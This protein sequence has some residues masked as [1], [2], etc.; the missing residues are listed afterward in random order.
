MISLYGVITGMPFEEQS[1][2][3]IER[4]DYLL[5]KSRLIQQK[6]DEATKHFYRVLQANDDLIAMLASS[7]HRTPLR[8]NARQLFNS[9]RATVSLTADDPLSERCE[10]PRR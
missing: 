7:R 4:A 3:L 8:I 6:A 5:R 1:R 10:E 9:S 2:A